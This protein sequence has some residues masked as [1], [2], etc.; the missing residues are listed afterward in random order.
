MIL[1]QFKIRKLD[2]FLLEEGAVEE[3]LKRYDADYSAFL[4][5]KKQVVKH[6]HTGL[7]VRNTLKSKISI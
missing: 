2:I 6:L 7:R 1:R 3:R 5:L 4:Q